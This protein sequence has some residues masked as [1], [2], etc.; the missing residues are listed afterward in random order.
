MKMLKNVLFHNVKESDDKFL[1]GTKM[2]W[3]LP[4]VITCPFTRFH[5]NHRR[6]WKHNL[7]RGGSEVN[8]SYN[9]NSFRGDWTFEP[10]QF[11]STALI[12]CTIDKR[13]GFLISLTNVIYCVQRSTCIARG[14]H[15]F[16]M[17]NM[18]QQ[19]IE[20]PLT[21]SRSE[22]SL[23]IFPAF[24]FLFCWGASSSSSSISIT[25]S[26]AAAWSSASFSAG[27]FLWRSSSA[28]LSSGMSFP[29]SR[30]RHFDKVATTALR[31]CAWRAAG[32]LPFMF[33]SVPEWQRWDI[34]GNICPQRTLL[35]SQSTCQLWKVTVLQSS[36]EQKM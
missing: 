8:R 20:I 12:K 6:G 30:S 1:I 31:A 25:A 18:S 13:T 17:H 4:W 34:I 33:H 28:C 3:I 10:R 35:M 22:K 23:S 29:A 2:F 36:H 16:C 7:Q 5:G 27:A 15:G 14:S 11:I 9:F 19:H 32:R 26:S 24:P 21:G